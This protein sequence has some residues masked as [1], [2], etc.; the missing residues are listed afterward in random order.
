MHG[1]VGLGALRD[2]LL[3][4]T[5]LLAGL[6]ALVAARLLVAR[7]GAL[8]PVGEPARGRRAP[9]LRIAPPRL[10]TESEVEAIYG[11]AA[12]TI[13]PR[14]EPAPPRRRRPSRRRELVSSGSHAVL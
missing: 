4:A 14:A 12:P 7:V 8:D 5:P 13:T 1:L 2:A 9:T 11:R 3:A 6:G 10:P